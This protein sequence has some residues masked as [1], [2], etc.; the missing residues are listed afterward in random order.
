MVSQSP[1][2]TAMTVI[3][4]AGRDSMLLNLS[5]AHGPFFTRNIVVMEDS[6]GHR[7][8]GEV[9]GGEGIQKTLEDARALVVGQ[10][11]G[12]YKNVLIKVR[13]AFA[14]RDSG[15]RGLQTFDLRIASHAVTAL[16]AA[17]LDLLG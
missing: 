17:F 10:P 5:G 2:V 8:V 14:D 1:I 12:A 11:I 3:T 4:V 15:G 7:G 13:R 9:P 6:S 16:E